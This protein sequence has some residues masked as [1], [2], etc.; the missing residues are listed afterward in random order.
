MTLG[1][2]IR[3]LDT[4]ALRYHAGGFLQLLGGVLVLPA[5]AAVGFGEW[6]EAALLSGTAVVVAGSGRLARR[7][8]VPGLELRE[9]MALAAVSYLAAAVAGAVAFLGV[10]APVDALFESMSG[11]TTTGLTV[12]DVEELPR[13]LLLLRALSQWIGGGGI[14]VLSVVVLAGPGSSAMRLYAAELGGRTLVGSALATGRA[15][16][17]VYLG[18][19][20][21]ALAA[22]LVAGA[23]LFDGLLHALALPSTGGFSPFDDSIGGYGSPA[24]AGLTIAFM[25]LGA[26]SF[27]LYYL[28]WRR[29]WRRLVGDAQVLALVALGAVAIVAFLAFEGWASGP[30]SAT[31]H[32]VSALTTTGFVIGDADQWSDGSRL[33]IMGLMVIGGSFGSTAGGLKILRLLILIRVVGWAVSRVMLPRAAKVPMKI[34]HAPVKEDEIRHTFAFTAAYAVLLLVSGL[35]LTAAGAPLQ[36][37]LFDSASALGTVGMSVGAVSADLASW[38]KLVVTVDMWA[39][40][41][42]ILALL[43]LL[44]PHNWKR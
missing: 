9:A 15:V 41:L 16:A 7:G 8:P 14:I 19:T 12:M 29:G 1:A 37:A 22:L 36:D 20:V 23:G 34:Q 39:G 40:R 27:P 33:L 31:F 5:A 43:V 25:A 24:I 6:R 11:F 2:F 28:A 42:E 4:A 30:L 17:T 32:A 3:P 44:H 26:I 10:A 13:S 21:L 18:M 35:V 38:A